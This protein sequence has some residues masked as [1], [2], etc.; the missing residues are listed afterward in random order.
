MQYERAEAKALIELVRYRWWGPALH[1]SP[2]EELHPLA[3]QL[4]SA[5]GTRPGFPD[6][7]LPIRSGEFVGCAIELKAAAPHKRQATPKQRAWLD[8]FDRQ[9]WLAKVCHGAQDALE[10]LDGYIA[11]GAQPPSD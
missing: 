9:G 8:H 2:N 10:T 3:R 4:A 6:Y 1:H 7:I 5:Q 11:L